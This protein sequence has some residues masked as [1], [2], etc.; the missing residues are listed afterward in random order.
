MIAMGTPRVK[1]STDITFANVTNFIPATAK[2]VRIL[3]NVAAKRT[4]A[5]LMPHVMMTQQEDFSVHVKLDSV[6]T[7]QIVGILMS[8]LV[9]HIIVIRTQP[10]KIPWGTSCVNA[11]QVTEAMEQVA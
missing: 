5:I 11:I 7:G 1:I 9:M 8:V 10:A 2:T 4:L 6:A 3:M